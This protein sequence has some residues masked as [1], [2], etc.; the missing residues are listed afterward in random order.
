MPYK[1]VI[2]VSPVPA[3]EEQAWKWL[4]VLAKTVDTNPP[5]LF[6]ELIDRLLSRYHCYTELLAQGRQKESVWSDGPLRNNI[7]L[8]APVI[9]IFD[10]RVGEALPFL[11]DTAN[12][13]ELT[14]F[15][16]QTETIHRP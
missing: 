16:P 11:I 10:D 1:V 15:D 9:G 3:D 4:D 14:V 8:L 13:L 12:Q 5:Q 7:E 2:T 6:H